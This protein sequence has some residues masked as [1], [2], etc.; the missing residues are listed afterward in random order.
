MC[1][2]LG[3]IVRFLTR[4][5]RLCFAA[6]DEGAVDLDA[7]HTF[8]TCWGRHYEAESEDCFRW[9]G[10]EVELDDCVEED[11]SSGD[12]FFCF[13]WMELMFNP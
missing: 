4:L 12:G 11:E 2:V 7:T 13:G 6:V 3:D 5:E 8:G 9:L 10:S 1:V